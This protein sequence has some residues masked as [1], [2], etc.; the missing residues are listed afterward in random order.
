MANELANRELSEQDYDLLLQLESAN[1]NLL[2]HIP[3][4]VIK[5]WPSEK[6]RENNLLL[7][8]G[9][10]CRI[11]LRAFQV[12]QTIRKIPCCKHKFHLDCID[13]WLLH[14][15][16]TCPV[17]GLVVW[18]PVTAQMEKEEKQLKKVQQ[19]NSKTNADNTNQQP[20][21][22]TKMADLTLGMLINYKTFVPVARNPP[23][24]EAT[25]TDLAILNHNSTANSRTSIKNRSASTSEQSIAG[26]K[27]AP[28]SGQRS[29]NEVRIEVAGNGLMLNHQ[30]FPASNNRLNKMP[31]PNIQPLNG[32]RFTRPAAK[33]LSQTSN[34]R[35]SVL[36]RRNTDYIINASPV[37]SAL[38]V[39]SLIRARP[40]QLTR[41]QADF[42][43]IDSDFDDDQDEKFEPASLNNVR[44]PS[45]LKLQNSLIAPE[46]SR[47]T[48]SAVSSYAIQPV[49]LNNQTANISDQATLSLVENT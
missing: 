7:N 43:D 42:D 2:S 48:T 18:D 1:K 32:T 29:I 33:N 5:S 9:H 28:G 8:P 45:E 44:V 46:V 17:D 25:K 37:D 20:D 30:I 22:N 24:N 13:N 35:E 34:A 19:S 41:L 47:L 3:E 49:D 4:K 27:N 31:L 12:N 23:I 21:K 6:I 38:N 11:C 36:F 16:P 15:H 14:S 39:T 40:Y 26:R 10:Q